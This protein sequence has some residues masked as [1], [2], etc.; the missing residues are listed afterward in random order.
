MSWIRLG[1]ALSVALAAIASP[2]LAEDR[3]SDKERRTSRRTS[4][5]TAARPG[6]GLFEPV[7]RWTARR[8]RTP[9]ETQRDWEALG[10]DPPKA[11]RR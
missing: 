7:I 8:Y 11:A 3:A 1:L 9:A 5:A 6:A 4:I 10:Y 2:A